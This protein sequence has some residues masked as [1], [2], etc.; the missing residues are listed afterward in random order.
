MV[1]MPAEWRSC[2]IESSHLVLGRPLG[3]FLPT[4]DVRV[5]VKDSSYR[6]GA[7]FASVGIQIMFSITFWTTLVFPYYIFDTIFLSLIIKASV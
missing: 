2:L 3:L 5:E 6:D 1:S 7:S 4:M